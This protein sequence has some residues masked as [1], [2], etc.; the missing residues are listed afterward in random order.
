MRIA[1]SSRGPDLTSQ[2]DEK[3][4]RCNY[5]VFVDPDSLASEPV[6]NTA[7][8]VSA[9]AGVPAALLVVNR[10]VQAVLTGEVGPSAAEILADAGITV[11]TGI[12]GTVLD[13][14]QG[15]MQGRFQPCHGPTV[16]SGFGLTGRR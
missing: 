13:A 14:V 8:S 3:F 1:V 2:V 16:S 11:V 7:A 10:G 15:F 9:G 4:G 6:T 5:F 12:R